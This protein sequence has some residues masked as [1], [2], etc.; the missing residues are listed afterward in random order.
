MQSLLHC[1]LTSRGHLTWVATLLSTDTAAAK[2]TPTSG[3]AGGWGCF[4]E[5][6][7]RCPSLGKCTCELQETLPRADTQQGDL[8]GRHWGELCTAGVSVRVCA[9]TCMQICGVGVSVQRDISFPPKGLQVCFSTTKLPKTLLRRLL[10]RS[11]KAAFLADGLLPLLRR[12][13]IKMKQF[14]ASD[15]PQISGSDQ[16]IT[17]NKN[18]KNDTH[19]KNITFPKKKEAK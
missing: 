13:Y 16:S 12:Q 6:T 11:R 10:H 8:L 19:E 1:Q 5:S 14:P 7:E 3:W 9:C 15:Q 4:P 18:I 2:Q 17:T